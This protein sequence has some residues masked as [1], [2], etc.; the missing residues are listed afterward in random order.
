MQNENK[1][2][3]VPKVERPIVQPNGGEDL[4]PKDIVRE[5]AGDRLGVRGARQ[6]SLCEINCL[7]TWLPR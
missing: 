5:Y 6:E 3:L 1:I 7:S 2:R 4:D